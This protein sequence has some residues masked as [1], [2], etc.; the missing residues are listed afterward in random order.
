MV[1]SIDDYL[2]PSLCTVQ[3]GQDYLRN[4]YNKGNPGVKTGKGIY[5]WIGVDMDAFR[6]RA[7]VPCLRFFNWDLPKVD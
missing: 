7:G 2:F 6:K 3:K 4:L 5:D 1:L